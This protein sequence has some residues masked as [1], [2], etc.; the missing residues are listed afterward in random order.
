V[1]TLGSRLLH[2]G[3]IQGF[4]S[5]G[6]IVESDSYYGLSFTST[7]SRRF[8]K[9]GIAL[10]AGITYSREHL[11]AETGDGVSFSLGASYARSGH[12]FDAYAENIGGSLDF[13]GHEYPIESRYAAGYGYSIVGGPGR[14]DLGAQVVFSNSE[15]RQVE[16]GGAYRFNRFMTFRAG[17][18]YAMNAAT[19]NTMP[20]SAGL[21]FH[22]GNFFFDYAYTSQEYFSATHTFSMGF[23]FG[24]QG[25]GVRENR[26]GSAPAITAP[27]IGE[28]EPVAGP[29]PDPAKVSIAAP[30]APAPESTRAPVVAAPKTSYVVVGGVHSRLESAEAEVRA[31]RLLKVNSSVETTGGQYRV[32]IGKFG[33][34]EQA[35]TAVASYENRGHKFRVLTQR[36]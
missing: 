3:D 35:E 20:L 7:V 29:D 28:S 14:L 21:G 19:E 34:R 24:G 30:A 13:A 23:L 36:P 27:V 17:Y 15:L 31:L 12:R 18:N 9:T 6:N 22:H 32:V 4:D 33:T 2:S 11:P 16:F 25:G 26:G 1:W 5:D 8:A 10:G